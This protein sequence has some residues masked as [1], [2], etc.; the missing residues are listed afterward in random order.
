MTGTPSNRPEAEEPGGS[1]VAGPSAA[2]AIAQ[3]EA[4]NARLR[5]RVAEL[6]AEATLRSDRARTRVGRA[7]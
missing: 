3:L 4:E 1:D 7:P 2:A 5:A 6:E